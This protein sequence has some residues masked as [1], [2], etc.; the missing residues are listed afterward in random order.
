MKIAGTSP[1]I[2][3]VNLKT[4]SAAAETAATATAG[5]A[6]AEA[7]ASTAAGATAST[8]RAGSRAKGR[9]GLHREQAFALHLLARELAG[10]AHRFRFLTGL[11]LGGLLKMAAK[12]HFA[13]NPLALH[14]LLERLEGLIDVVIADENLHRVVFLLSLELCEF[15]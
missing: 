3:S 15:G 14:L 1:A 8:G 9:L 2:A 13:E 4:G 7:A 12:L 6:A 10:A 5:T 11:L